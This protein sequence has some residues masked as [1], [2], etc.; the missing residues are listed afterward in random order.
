MLRVLAVPLVAATLGM[1]ADAHAKGWRICNG[2]PEELNVAIAYKDD[3][4]QWI[5][6]GWHNLQA[7]GGCALVM[8]HSRTEYTDVFFHARNRNGVERFGGPGRFC[9]MS[10]SFTIRNGARCV[11]NSR[12]ASFRKQ[13]ITN[14]NRDFTTNLTGG[15]NGRHCID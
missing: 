3:Q 14:E 15:A 12:I 9:V 8:N 2:T 4:D 10:Q 6:K 11:G 7:C 5:T 1:I 13:V